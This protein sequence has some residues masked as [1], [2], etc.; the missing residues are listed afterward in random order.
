MALRCTKYAMAVVARRS[1][2]G[3]GTSLKRRTATGPGV[4]ECYRVGIKI[5]R[6]RRPVMPSGINQNAEPPRPSVRSIVAHSVNIPQIAFL[7]AHL[8]PVISGVL[9]TQP[10]V[11]LRHL[12][13]GQVDILGHAT[14]IPTDVQLRTFL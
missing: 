9:L 3:G 7:L 6:L 4:T 12:A 2:A 10:A 1:G 14:G 13:Q 8:A 11:V 5:D